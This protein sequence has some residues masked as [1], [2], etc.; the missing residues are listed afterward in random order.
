MLTS[1]ITLQLE[2]LAGP[3]NHVEVEENLLNNKVKTITAYYG[4]KLV[5]WGREAKEKTDISLACNNLDN[6]L[7]A[8]KK[9]VANHKTSSCLFDSY[10]VEYFG[11]C[12]RRSDA[13]RFEHLKYN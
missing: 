2:E 1:P 11:P 7:C 5:K 10:R 3:G 4:D 8:S 13:G 6:K 9:L 12:R